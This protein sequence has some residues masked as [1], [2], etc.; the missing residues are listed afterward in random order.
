[1]G[2]ILALTEDTPYEIKLTLTDPDGVDGSAESP[3]RT[4]KAVVSSKLSCN[5]S[6]RGRA[7]SINRCDS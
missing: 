2:S 6:K 1:M 3:R 4:Y 5:R 7:A